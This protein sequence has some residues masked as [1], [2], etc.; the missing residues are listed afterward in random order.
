MYVAMV[1]SHYYS[2]IKLKIELEINDEINVYKALSCIAPCAIHI[3]AFLCISQGYF[4][5]GVDI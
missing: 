5:S 2:V 1:A 4:L 3:L